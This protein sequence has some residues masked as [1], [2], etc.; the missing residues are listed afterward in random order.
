MEEAEKRVKENDNSRSTDCK[1]GTVTKQSLIPRRKGFGLVLFCK[2]DV[3]SCIKGTEHKAQYE[4]C[5]KP[6]PSEV[7][8]MA[9]CNSFHFSEVSFLP[10]F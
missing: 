2:V 8:Q 6:S 7:M 1:V 9:L 4:C 5:E 3:C 10:S